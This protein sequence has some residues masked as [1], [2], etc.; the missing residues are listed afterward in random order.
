MRIPQLFIRTG[1]GYV[2]V[3]EPVKDKVLYF[4]DDEEQRILPVEDRLR[5]KRVSGMLLLV[6]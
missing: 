4:W 2:P 1:R 6:C 5:F 3:S